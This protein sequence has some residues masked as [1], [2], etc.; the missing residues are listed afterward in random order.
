MLELRNTILEMIAKGHSLA[1]T[2]KCMCHEVENLVQGSLCLIVTMD[3]EGLISSLA[4]PS[5][6]SVFTSAIEDLRTAATAE[7]CQITN[8]LLTGETVNDIEN[9]P[10]CSTF[11]Q[12]TVPF[13]LRACW[14]V[15]ILD[16]TGDT[17]GVF[18]LY[19]RDRRGPTR[20]EQE[21]AQHCVRLCVIALDRHQRVLEHERRAFTDA[22]TGLANR[23]AF[24]T[25]LDSMDCDQPDSWG[26]LVLDLDNLK[27]VNGTFGHQAGDCLLK[28]PGRGSP[29]WLRRSGH[30]GS[31]ATSSPSY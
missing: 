27:I 5:L 24:D 17:I 22:L 30:S 16:S 2:A 12:L 29:R 10:R 3:R 9:D 13:G 1:S 21:I 25:A 31:A 15:P 23:A 11:K 20:L 8:W 26:L 6:P 14:S 28:V 19:Y 7:T 4:G 18:A